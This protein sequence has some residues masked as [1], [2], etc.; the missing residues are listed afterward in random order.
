VFASASGSARS[1][2]QCATDMQRVKGKGASWRHPSS[3][4][5]ANDDAIVHQCAGPIG[6]DQRR[7]PGIVERSAL[8]AR[9]VAFP[10]VPALAAGFPATGLASKIRSMLRRIADGRT[11]RTAP[12]IT[13]LPMVGLWIPRSRR[14][15][16]VRSKPHSS[17]SPS[18]ENPCATRIWRSA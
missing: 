9:A 5:R 4:T 7:G 15:T 3:L 16:Y 1:G 14:L 11:R 18:W 12:S 17:A 13:S 2:Y 6:V 10:P 8:P